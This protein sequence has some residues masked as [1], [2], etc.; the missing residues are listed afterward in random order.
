MMDSG[1]RDAVAHGRRLIRQAM[2]ASRRA[3]QIDESRNRVRL[4]LR[5]LSR[6]D[7]RYAELLDRLEE[8]WQQF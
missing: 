5:C 7:D 8:S 2:R 6:Y 1:T 3:Q 4:T